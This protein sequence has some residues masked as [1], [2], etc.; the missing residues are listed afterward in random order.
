VYASKW[1]FF[2]KDRTYR[3]FFVLF[4]KSNF[5]LMV[6]KDLNA[7]LTFVHATETAN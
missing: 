1:V 3:A 6:P 4:N 7:F 5:F 2:S